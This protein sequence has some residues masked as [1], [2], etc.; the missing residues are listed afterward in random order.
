MDCTLERAY[1]SHTG[2]QW[3][4]KEL[5]MDLKPVVVVD[6]SSSSAAAAAATLKPVAGW[7][8]LPFVHDVV[9]PLCLRHKTDLVLLDAS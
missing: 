3:L 4:H 8:L 6:P 5:R 7:P 9:Q 2:G 1:L